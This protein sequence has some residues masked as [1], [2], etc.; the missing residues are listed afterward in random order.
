MIFLL[1]GTVIGYT[2]SSG[3]SI[4]VAVLVLLAAW[5][6]SAYLILRNA[7][8]ISVMLCRGFLLGA[9]EWLAVIPGTR[10]SPEDYQNVP[11]SGTGD[12]WGSAHEMGTCP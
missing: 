12:Y 4:A 10:T 3:V 7:A 11:N 9:V 8:T 6:G 1:A 5:A 2:I